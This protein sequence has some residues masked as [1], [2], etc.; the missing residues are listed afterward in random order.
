M[1]QF[2]VIMFEVAERWRNTR[3]GNCD[4]PTSLFPNFKNY[5][6]PIETSHRKYAESDSVNNSYQWKS[7]VSF[8]QIPIQTLSTI[9]NAAQNTRPIGD[10]VIQ[11]LQRVQQLQQQYNQLQG[12]WNQGGVASGSSV[13]VY[14]SGSSFPSYLSNSVYSSI[15]S[16]LRRNYPSR[17]SQIAGVSVASDGSGFRIWT[18]SNCC[19][20]FTFC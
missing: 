15:Q 6:R 3:G 19:C 14:S 18:N 16:G 5:L 17:A 12:N 9:N 4:V 20:S 2:A 11:R 1:S 13:S 8:F 10:V 7:I